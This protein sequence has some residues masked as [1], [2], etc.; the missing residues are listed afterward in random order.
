MHEGEKT[1]VAAAIDATVAVL[2]GAV[3]VR[4]VQPITAKTLYDYVNTNIA[5]FVRSHMSYESVT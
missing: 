5:G 2:D 1:H 3:M 4:M